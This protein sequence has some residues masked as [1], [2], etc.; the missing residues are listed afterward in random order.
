MGDIIIYKQNLERNKGE[1]LTHLVI[2]AAST[3]PLARRVLSVIAAHVA[4]GNGVNDNSAAYGHTNQPCGLWL[5]IALS[6]TVPTPWPNLARLAL[7]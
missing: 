6:A 3:T 4:E 7:N 5:D 2:R 1:H